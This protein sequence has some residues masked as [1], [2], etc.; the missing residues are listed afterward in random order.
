MNYIEAPVSPS[1]AGAHSAVCYTVSPEARRELLRRLLALNLE[2]AAQE[3]GVTSPRP[4]PARGG[5]T[6]MIG[7]GDAG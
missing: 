3:A 7:S 2:L 6:P 1:P 4:S 5:S